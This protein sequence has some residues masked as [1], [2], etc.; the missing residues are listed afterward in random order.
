MQ[1]QWVRKPFE[2]HEVLTRADLL[3]SGHFRRQLSSEDS[4]RLVLDVVSRRW[5]GD[6][7][8]LV[9]VT[10]VN[11]NRQAKPINENCF[12]QCG[13]SVAAGAMPV[14]ALSGAAGRASGR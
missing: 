8:R 4:G 1:K 14:C 6:D 11:D 9:T 7:R 13:F 5:E 12:F 2:K 3:K 10:L